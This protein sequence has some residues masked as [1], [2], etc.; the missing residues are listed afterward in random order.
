MVDLAQQ[1]LAFGGECRVSVP[2]GMDLG[3]GVIASFLNAC[4][5]QRAVDGDVQQRDEIAERV[6]YQIIGRAGL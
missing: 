1:H 5:A 4:L 2:R 3:L 6:L